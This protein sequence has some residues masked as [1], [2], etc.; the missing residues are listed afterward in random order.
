MNRPALPF[1][2]APLPGE[3]FDSWLEAYAARLR[4]STGELAAA[5]GLPIHHLRTQIGVLLTRGLPTSHLTPAATAAGL[6]IS[7][8]AAMFH[9]PGPAP[10]A[11]RPSTARAFRNAWAPA[12]GTRFCPACLAG[13]QGRYLLAWRLPWT[14][15]CLTHDQ[16]LASICPTAASRPGPG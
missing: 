6:P 1:T 11:Q 4:S 8:L 12:A 7:A 5:V 10:A 14:F 3:S 2:L 16:L 13:N 15:Y 9:H